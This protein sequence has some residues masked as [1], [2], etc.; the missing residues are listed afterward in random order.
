MNILFVTE[1]HSINNY[2][3][4]SVVSQLVDQLST[5][6]ENI[7]VTV[8]S[9]GSET[10][11]QNA[12]V[13]IV[14]VPHSNLGR[15][16]GWSELLA[17]TIKQTIEKE[18][19]DLIHIHGIWMAAQWA[20][21]RVAREC[22]IQCVV[23]PHGML[24]NWLWNKQNLLQKIKKKIYFNFI[25]HPA[26][27]SQVV[28]HA[29]TP[30]EFESLNHQLPR[31]RK[32]TIPNA[33]DLLSEN[34]FQEN[35]KPEKQFL[36]LGRIHP[37]KAIEV[38]IDAF[39]QAKLDSEWKLMIAGPEYVPEYVQGL[40][41]KVRHSKMED[42]IIFTGPIYGEQKLSILQKTWALVIPS[43]SEV[44]GMV[45]LEAAIQKVPSITTFETGLWDWEDGGGLLIH[46]NV[47]E[48][49]STLKIV[50]EWKINERLEHGKRSYDLVMRKYSWNSVIPKWLDFYTSLVND[51]NGI[52]D[53]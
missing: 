46:P 30:I 40:K 7:H 4:T 34:Q 32:V 8:L 3:I 16:W 11:Q 18:K 39:I 38:L 24:E 43:Y 13:N 47:E 9:I 28:F 25:F 29:I 44:M 2:G 1:D 49:T 41:E 31:Y 17:K 12:K 33:I 15:F 27:N 53:K 5:H 6:C 51:P 45:N 42:Q 14:L 48:L 52:K 22:G 19:I 50:S 20:A 35:D 36:F 37:V 21:L 10:V 23:S 26:L